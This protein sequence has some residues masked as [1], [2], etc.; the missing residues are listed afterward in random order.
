M[1]QRCFQTIFLILLFLLVFPQLVHAQDSL[2]VRWLGGWPYGQAAQLSAAEINGHK[3]CFQ[4][5]GCGVLIIDVTDPYNPYK[6]SQIYGQSDRPRTDCAYGLLFLAEEEL[7]LTIYDVSDP[8]SPVYLSRCAAAYAVAAVYVR[9]HYAYIIDGPEMRVID[10]TDPYAP[11][12]V[13]SCE[14]NPSDWCNC[15]TLR[16][17]YA[18]CTGFGY[19]LYVID[20][21]DSLNPYPCFDTIGFSNAYHITTS[22]DLLFIPHH[23]GP[24][25]IYDLTEPDHPVRCG[26]IEMH[27]VGTWVEVH[28]TLAFRP[29][30]DTLTQLY[31]FGVYDISDT[32]AVVR[33]GSIS[34]PGY[35]G[36]GIVYMDGYVYFS[37]GRGGLRIIDVSDPTNPYETAFYETPGHARS[38]YVKDNY[39]YY[40]GEQLLTIVDVS[41]PQQCVDLGTWSIQNERINEI[42]VQ[43]EYLYATDDSGGMSIID[44]SDPYNPVQTGYFSQPQTYYRS[45]GVWAQDTFAYVSYHTSSL[46]LK[47]LNVADPYNPFEAGEYTGVGC[48]YNIEGSGNHIYLTDVY[49]LH[50]INVE[51]PTAPYQEGHLDAMLGR[52]SLADNYLYISPWDSLY[53]V[54]VSNPANPYLETMFPIKSRDVYA[55]AN[56]YVYLTVLGTYTVRIFDFSDIASPIELGYYNDIPHGSPGERIFYANDYI[57]VC[58]WYGGLHIYEYY[59]TGVEEMTTSTKERQLQVTYAGS[60]IEIMY[61]L[62]AASLVDMSIVD[63]AGRVIWQ[64]RQY[65]SPGLHTKSIDKEKFACGVYF[66][67]VQTQDWSDSQKVLIIQ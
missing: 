55:A 43:G 53:V 41:D 35:G 20:I 63:V 34:I 36:Y 49:G 62:D 31:Y 28:D 4:T 67:V 66:L 50:V 64:N 14:P 9:N 6:V 45:Y 25:G 19:Q 10:C 47:V 30:K 46:G 16:G 32:A 51:D 60:K 3:Y 38:I 22:E 17:D 18:Y 61:Y 12:E 33:I 2:N 42:H 52:I 48:Q 65:K 58:Q 8:N 23:N 40:M 39:A 54:N 13:A 56:N 15:I 21:S 27:G 1:M 7:G 26:I 37:H 29:Y 59:G 24:T 5:A 57:Y 11:H 44:V